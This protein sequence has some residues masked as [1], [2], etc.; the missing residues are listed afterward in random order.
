MKEFVHGGNVYNA[1][2]TKGRW[3]DMSANINP[4]GIPESVRRAVTE[5]IDDIVHYPDPEAKVF[6]AAVTARY[7]IDADAVVAG[8][9]AAEL[10]YVY[11]HAKKP[12]TVILPVP[13]FSEYEKAACAAGSV[14]HYVR[15]KEEDDF[16]ADW[17]AV[18]DNCPAKA[19]IVL[20]NPNNPTGN[21]ISRETLER[22]L[23][24]GAAR[25][26]QF[27]VDESFLD[28]REDEAL[29]SVMD[30][31]SRN[32]RLFVLRS[33]TKFYALPG[34]RLGFGVTHKNVCKQL[35]AHKD[36][37]NVN[38]LAQYA[39]AAALK[40]AAYREKTLAFIKK[41]P[42]AMAEKLRSLTGLT[43]FG[44]TV[45]FLLVKIK[46]SFG[47]GTDCVA[48]LRERGILARPCHMYEGLNAQF[49]RLAVKN[50]RDNET[51][52]KE[53]HNYIISEKNAKVKRL[54]D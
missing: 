52:I 2:G 23:K 4:F 5:H 50:E 10:L 24:A 18:V 32:E 22:C 1:D 40:D 15:L 29:Y 36:C 26:V 35:E 46:P 28:F 20:C 42:Y 33:L 38:T 48:Y 21:L 3:L 45:N 8:N 27:V 47:S 12:K 34:L 25:D 30:L 31:A 16:A 19:C 41:E 17:E 37:W 53:I 51:V 9:G 13:T 11:F 43:V 39:G 14:I 49:M 7:G 6:K 44:G 54:L